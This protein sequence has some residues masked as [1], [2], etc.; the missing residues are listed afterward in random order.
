MCQKVLAQQKLNKMF[1]V[2][3]K[4]RVGRVTINRHIF[5]FGLIML[6]CLTWC[7]VESPNFTLALTF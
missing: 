3:G 4:L 1:R 2:G 5:Y 6:L 7:K